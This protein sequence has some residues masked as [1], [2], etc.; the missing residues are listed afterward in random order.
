MSGKLWSPI[1]WSA[2]RIAYLQQ[3]WAAKTSTQIAT[4]LSNHTEGGEVTRSAVTGKARKLNLPRKI[5]PDYAYTYT[6]DTAARPY[7]PGIDPRPDVGKWL[8]N[9]P[10]CLA[11][12][13]P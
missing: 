5:I 3:H 6:E 1:N 10:E 13:V 11:S 9:E 4:Y 2:E 8:Q 7:R 12:T